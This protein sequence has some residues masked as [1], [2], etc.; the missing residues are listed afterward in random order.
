MRQ[1]PIQASLKPIGS[2]VLNL[3]PCLRGPALELSTLGCHK[4]TQQHTLQVFTENSIWPALPEP[5]SYRP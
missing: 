4:Y 5:I 2:I 3:I 1:E